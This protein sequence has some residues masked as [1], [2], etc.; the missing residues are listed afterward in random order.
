[1]TFRKT[2]LSF[3]VLLPALLAAC[4][5]GT[6]PSTDRAEPPVIEARVGAVEAV[7]LPDVTWVTGTVKAS[8]RVEA[9]TKIL[10]RVDRLA[11]EEGEAVRRGQLLVQLEDGDLRA[12]V[13]QAEAAVA[14]AEAQ[15]DNAGAQHAR[16]QSLHERGS[17]TDKNLEDAVAGL[18]VAEASVEQAKANVQAAK[19]TLAY[20]RVT[21]P[22]D[23]V[24][25][26][27]F[28]EEGDMARPGAPLVAVEDLSAVDVVAQVPEALIAGRRGGE[29]VRVEVLGA[30]YDAE[31]ERVVPAGD[32]V[33]RTFQVEVKLEN[34]SGTFRS[35]MFARVAFEG[36]TTEVLLLPKAAL[37]ERGQLRG[38]WVVGDDG[39]ATVRW[40]RLGTESADGFE[41]LSGLEGGERVILDPPAG[42]VDGTRVREN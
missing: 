15:R 37:V 36:G 13:S 4:G 19:A 42:L 24:V 35:G 8:R 30:E 34:E 3:L 31:I 32:A 25:A 6:D 20:T 21:S 28:V 14:M 39:S 40:L 27:K 10:G 12:A 23:G 17:V 5:G 29:A 11:A 16:M 38:A 2:R 41:V 9:G 18:R 1:M 26:G 33:S 7:S 22:F